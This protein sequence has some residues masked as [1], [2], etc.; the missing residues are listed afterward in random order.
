MNVQLNEVVQDDNDGVYTPVCGVSLLTEDLAE[1]R[2][3]LWKGFDRYVIVLAQRRAGH[4]VK[5]EKVTNAAGTSSA[6][7]GEHLTDYDHQ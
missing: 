5:S 6:L 7:Q 1:I 2:L 3:Y 4:A